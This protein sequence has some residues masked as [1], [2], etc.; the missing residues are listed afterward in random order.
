MKADLLLRERFVISRRAFVE[1]VIWKLSRP[2][3]ECNHPF[4]YRMAYVANGRCVLR[5]DNE[6]GKGDHQH[7]NEFEVPYRFTNLTTLQSDFWAIVRR[8]RRGR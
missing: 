5:F 4:K 2:L 6:V 7:V 8:R 1:I 3:S